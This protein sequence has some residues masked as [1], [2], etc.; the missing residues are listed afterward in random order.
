VLLNPGRA[1]RAA[2]GSVL[3]VAWKAS[4]AVAG[5]NIFVRSGVD[6]ETQVA[7]NVTGT[8]FKDI[9]LPASVSSSSRV[10]VRIQ[11][12][13]SSARQDSVDG[14]FM[15]RGASPS[16]EPIAANRK[17]QIGSIKMLEWTGVS[18]SYTVDLDL[19]GQ[20][21]TSIARNLPDF[22][23]YTWL[24]P[25]AP[26]TSATVRVS[27][28][29]TNGN[30]VG[31][32]TGE[33]FS[34]VADLN[35]FPPTRDDLD[36]D[37][38]SDIALFRP[39]DGTWYVRYSSLGYTTGDAFKWGVEGDL[40]VAGDYDGDGR[41]DIAVF[42]PSDGI[43]YIRYTTTGTTA[44]FKWGAMGDVP[45]PGDY[46]GDGKTDLAI[47]RPSTGAWWVW[48]TGS[49][50]AAFRW[51]DA[52]DLPVPGDYNG[53]GKTDFAVYRPSDGAWWIWYSGTET[54]A[55]F[56]WGASGDVPVVGD[57]NG[58]GTTD[59]TIFRPSTGTWWIWNTG[60]TVTTFQW[61]LEGDVP[62]SGDFDGDGKTDFAVF[63]PSTGVWWIYYVATGTSTA[64]QWGVGSDIPVKRER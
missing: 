54:I 14:Y 44:G 64:L 48:Y 57:F 29:D 22:G 35:A 46:N 45:A 36:G 5:V 41:T 23:S 34:V 56:R 52:G 31:A 51:G 61:G 11:D 49:T 33:T 7:S 63:R 24:V 18:S 17:L 60:S 20:T 27:F 47:Y 58:D 4:P 8:T 42:R 10:T 55:G 25:D 13:G 1:T 6:N 21:T 15:V 53:D 40:P 32:V 39:S 43:W 38:K 28:K 26:S 2:D 3:R 50:T 62:V 9:T 19:V 59:L 37:G 12:S 30:P 16:L